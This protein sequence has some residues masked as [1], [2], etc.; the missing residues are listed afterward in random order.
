MDTLS[1]EPWLVTVANRS[2][3]SAVRILAVL[4][5]VP[6][7]RPL[8]AVL[9]FAPT[10]TFFVLSVAQDFFCVDALRYPYSTIWWSLGAV[11]VT[12]ALIEID[13][14]STD[15][16]VGCGDPPMGTRFLTL[17]FLSLNINGI[18]SVLWLIPYAFARIFLGARC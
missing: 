4:K 18:I 2:G 17:V 12:S 10:V 7:I 13:T 6:S 5:A 3:T 1:D 9:L 8:S 14:A 11:V 15:R 16:L